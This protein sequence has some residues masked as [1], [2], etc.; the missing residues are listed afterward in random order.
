MTK[1]HVTFADETA[2]SVVVHT[3]LAYEVQPVAQI[4]VNDQL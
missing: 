1:I 3:G 4:K 2:S